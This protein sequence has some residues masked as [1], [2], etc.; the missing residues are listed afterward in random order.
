MKNFGIHALTILI[1]LLLLVA[2]PILTVRGE[3]DRVETARQLSDH[4]RATVAA[5]SDVKITRHMILRVIPIYNSTVIKY[6]YTA[7]GD[8]TLEGRADI[9]SDHVQQYSQDEAHFRPGMPFP[10]TYLPEMPEKSLPLSELP[11]SLHFHWLSTLGYC[12][13]FFCMAAILMAK[14]RHKLDRPQ[15]L[16]PAVPAA[17]SPERPAEA[18]A[19][20]PPR[21]QPSAPAQAAATRRLAAGAKRTAFGRRGV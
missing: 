11:E 9:G 18:A 3:L 14:L 2:A 19:A 13:S 12:L 21:H 6:K 20:S 8:T 10:L 16:V 5:L 1:G 15:R 17:L 4:G 7:E